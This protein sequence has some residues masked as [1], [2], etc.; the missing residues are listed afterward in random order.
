MGQYF[1]VVNLDRREF[2]RF[3]AGKLREIVGCR[4]FGVLGYLLAT[5][6]VDGTVVGFMDE[7]EWFG[8]W[9]GDRIALV[10]DYAE[11]AK[12]F[13]KVGVSYEDVLE[14]FRDISDEVLREFYR[15]LSV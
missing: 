2:L 10:G 4:D 1:V 7:W 11:D 15:F 9:C 14:G 5:D 6:N 13:M 12:N 8:R 3:G